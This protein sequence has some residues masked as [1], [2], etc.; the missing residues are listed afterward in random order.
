MAYGNKA[1]RRENRTGVTCN[2]PDCQM[3]CDSR[4]SKCPH[5]SEHWGQLRIRHHCNQA[6]HPLVPAP[7]IIN[8]DKGQAAITFSM[9]S[10]RNHMGMDILWWRSFGHRNHPKKTAKPPPPK[11]EY[12]QITYQ[13][14]PESSWN[15]LLE[16]DDPLTSVAICRIL[17]CIATRCEDLVQS[18]NE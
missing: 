2:K 8:S 13:I 11:N 16:S 4:H 7:R 3:H 10:K 17:E 18:I 15:R 12:G 6:G 14:F 9:N 1:K 5:W